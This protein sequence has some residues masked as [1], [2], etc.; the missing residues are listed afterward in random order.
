[1][2]RKSGAH[3]AQKACHSALTSSSILS[4]T[5]QSVRQ[6]TLNLYACF[7]Y[8]FYLFTVCRHSPAGFRDRSGSGGSRICLQSKGEKVKYTVD[9]TQPEEQEILSTINV[10]AIMLNCTVQGEAP[11]II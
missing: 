10:F 1:M 6:S 5:C 9:H 4:G 7:C 8:L 11:F 2:H 3:T